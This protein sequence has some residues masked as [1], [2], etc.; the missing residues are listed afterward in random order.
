MGKTTLSAA[1]ALRAAQLGYKTLVMST[2]VA[3]SL[4]DSLQMPLGNEPNEVGPARLYGAEL[5]ASAELERYWGEIKRHIASTLQDQ[6]INGAIAGEL[7]ILPGLDELLS[8]IRIK[9]YNDTNAFDVLIIDSAPTGAAMRLLSAPDI[10]RWYT[11]NITQF[12]KG[13]ARML[14][15]FVQSLTT[16]P[17]T[18]SAV[19]KKVRELFDE[20]EELRQLLTDNAQTSVRLVLNPERMSIQETQRAFTYFSLFGLAVDALYVNR[21]IPAEVQ[22]PYFA[23][24][25]TDQAAYCAEI[26]KTFAPLPVFEVALM[27]QEVVGL[28]A[29]RNIAATLYPNVDPTPPQTTA[30]PLRFELQDEK[31]MLYLR[32][33]APP[34]GEIDLTKHGDELHIRI[35]NYKRAIMLP[36]YVA[37][38]QPT[39]ASVEGE[40]LKVVF[41]E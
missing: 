16:L 38:L 1:T 40:Y 37:G 36:Q 7:A 8:L 39:W 9:R 2:D 26:V 27:R 12:T 35:G 15:P 10:N 3:H 5:D 29:L 22:D 32:M 41:E 31:Y 20:V 21:V 23:N 25:K 19:Q 11:K 6:G 34:K 24:W 30:H 14:T 17:I 33:V 28:D 13:L 18:D 4:A